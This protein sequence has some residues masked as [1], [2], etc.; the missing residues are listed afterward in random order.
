M[1]GLEL[2]QLEVLVV[3]ETAH[4][5]VGGSLG[6]GLSPHD[7]LYWFHLAQLDRLWAMWQDNGHQGLLHYPHDTHYPWGAP[8][9]PGHKLNDM[10]WP[11]I[12]QASGYYPNVPEEVFD[13][14]PDCTH[15]PPRFVKDTLSTRDMGPLGAYEYAPSP[16]PLM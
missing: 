12:G 15:E 3:P 16:E 11:W 1:Y 5:L 10:M 13:C 4:R 2:S 14:L 7:P 6:G 8:I 9:P